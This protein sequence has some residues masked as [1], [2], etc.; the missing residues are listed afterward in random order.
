MTD[1][2][3]SLVV[4]AGLG[5]D[6]GGVWCDE[7]R[8]VGIALSPGGLFVGWLDVGWTATG[9]P[10]DELRDVAH[11]PRSGSTATLRRDV[12]IAL[13]EARSARG[14]H[15]RRCSGCGDRLVPGRMFAADRCQACAATSDGLGRS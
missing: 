3:I 10:F 8:T 13:E 1:P 2:A 4:A 7:E 15:L 12:D 11:L 14:E 9:A 6:C 5:H